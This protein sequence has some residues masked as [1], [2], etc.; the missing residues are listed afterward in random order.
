MMPGPPNSR[1][2]L[3]GVFCCAASWPPPSLCAFFF[4]TPCDTFS[5]DE[6]LPTEKW[7]TLIPP[8]M[9]LCTITPHSLFIILS[10][11]PFSPLQTLLVPSGKDWCPSWRQ[12]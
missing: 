11:W 12:A 5:K 4:Q 3:V 10:I 8:A 7:T 6:N 9:P 2:V 1:Y